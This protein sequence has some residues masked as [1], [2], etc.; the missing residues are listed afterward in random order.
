MTTLVII[1]TYNERENIDPIVSRVRVAV[2]AVAVLIVDDGSP[3]GT[4]ERA[5]AIAAIDAQVTVIHRR[6]KEGLGAAYREGMRWGL[7][8]GFSEIVQMDA[9]GSHQ[10]EQLS[11]LL[12]HVGD[13]DVVVGS[14]WVSGGGVVNWP[15]QRLLLSRA[16]SGYARV[17]LGL[18]VHDAT[19]GYRAFTADA[20]RRIGL[21]SVHS[22]GYCFQIDMI[23]RAANAGLRIAEVPITFVDR[24]RGVSKMSGAIA[25]EAMLRVTGWGLRS[26]P[27]RV[28]GRAGVRLT[29]QPTHS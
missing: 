24:E 16:G 25:V 17:A 1:P 5:D 2:P 29:R 12:A 26:L 13:A 11:R 18:P 6:R 8:A 23:W 14:R 3:D 20:L 7:D 10:P 28:R 9:D 15:R 19:G 27:D 22:Q 4:G 21:D